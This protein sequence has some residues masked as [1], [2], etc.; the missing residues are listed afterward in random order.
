MCVC[1]KCFL[2]LENFLVLL[3]IHQVTFV[4]QT[5]LSKAMYDVRKQ[6]SEQCENQRGVKVLKSFCESKARLYSLSFKI[7]RDSAVLVR[8]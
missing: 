8:Q 1:L 7:E 6:V 5:L 2:C 4:W 3:Y